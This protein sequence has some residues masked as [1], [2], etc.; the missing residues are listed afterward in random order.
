M[1]CMVENLG[2]FDYL[3]TQDLCDQNR[4]I[5]VRN[6]QISNSLTVA[7][8]GRLG[9]VVEEL[10]RTHGI[11]GVSLGEFDEE[12]YTRLVGKLFHRNR[13]R[14]IAWSE[15]TPPPYLGAPSDVY[16]IAED[17]N[18]LRTRIPDLGDTLRP[19]L[20]RT[21]LKCEFRFTRDRLTDEMEGPESPSQW[22]KRFDVSTTTFTRMVKARIL[23]VRKLSTKRI[24]I[25]SADVRQH[26][27]T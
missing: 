13:Y 6:L 26:E 8:L 5:I 21:R 15:A 7:Y 4:P 19:S 17:W 10:N 18:A 11:V 16:S 12:S 25:N 3:R 23:R 2:V 24:L 22:A 9:A 1:L 14:I 27:K 20:L